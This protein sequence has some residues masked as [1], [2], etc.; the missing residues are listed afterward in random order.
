MRACTRG[1]CADSCC[2]PC[3]H[4]TEEL[5]FGD[6]DTLLLQLRRHAARSQ[7]AV[8]HDFGAVSD[9]D[10]VARSRQDGRRG[11][12]QVAIGIS[13]NGVVGEGVE[14]FIDDPVCDGAH[15][16][17]PDAVVLIFH[18]AAARQQTRP[19]VA[20]PA[21][22]ANVVGEYLRARRAAVRPVHGGRR[23]VLVG[24]QLAG[25]VRKA[26]GLLQDEALATLLTS[27]SGSKSTLPF[28]Q[29]AFT[30]APRSRLPSMFTPC[31]SFAGCAEPGNE[32]L[33]FVTFSVEAPVFSSRSR[34]TIF[35]PAVP[36]EVVGASGR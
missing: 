12:L 33:I 30:P 8:N 6:D 5:A 20:V 28:D 11:K 24:A 21:D 7:M 23:V 25:R 19:S 16:L 32:N 17:V 36:S 31:M 35:T 9:G 22:D 2:C 29:N 14:P 15:R 4:A 26:V 13:G 18:L 10:A 27:G 3:P 1:A 34:R